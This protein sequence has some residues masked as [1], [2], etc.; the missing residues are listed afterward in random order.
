MFNKSNPNP[1]MLVREGTPSEIADSAP[2]IIN[3]EPFTTA[4]GEN[5]YLTASTQPKIHGSIWAPELR[6]NTP[7]WGLVAVFITLACCVGAIIIVLVSNGQNVEAW[8]VQPSVL[9]AILMAGANAT[10]MFALAG[11][12]TNAWWYTVYKGATVAELHQQW[13]FGMSLWE[14]MS[15]GRHMGPV[16]FATIV[17]TWAIFATDPLMQRSTN[18]VSANITGSVNVVASIAPLIPYGYTGITTG[19]G[20]GDSD[21][22]IVAPTIPAMDSAR[23]YFN[24]V[25]ITTGFTG[26]KGNCNPPTPPPGPQFH[27]IDIP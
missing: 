25:P 6:K 17:G 4:I 9:L 23:D 12:V 16:A 2:T 15:A 5:Q 3:K 26:C 10:L 8:K 18:V 24:K 13:S 22:S 20:G 27:C 19:V 11:G 1:S 7:G 21:L 14:A